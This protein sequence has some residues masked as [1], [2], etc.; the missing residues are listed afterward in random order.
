MSDVGQDVLDAHVCLSPARWDELL[1]FV[2]KTGLALVF[3]LNIMKGRGVDGQGSFNVPNARALLKYTASKHPS[4]VRWLAFEVG[5][6]PS[7]LLHYPA[8]R[9][10]S[11]PSSPSPSPSLPLSYTS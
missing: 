4:G 9:A 2:Q 8:L 11:L 7:L 5:P 6:P 10:P 1:G 3:T